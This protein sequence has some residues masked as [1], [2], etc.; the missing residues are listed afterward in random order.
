MASLDLDFEL[1]LPAFT[2]SAAL[3]VGAETLALVGP[4]GAGKTT[5][6]RAVAGLADP[7]RGSI[8]LD[9][10]A[11]FESERDLSLPPEQ[12]S[13]G[14][15]FQDYALFPH[16]SVRRNVAFGARS[17]EAE[18]D[19]LLERFRIAPLREAKPTTLS[20]G[21]RQRVA[22]ARALARRP[23][24]LLL[25]EPLSALDAHTR[26]A[27]KVELQELLAE[28]SLPTIFITHDFRDAAALADRA[29]ALV[30]GRVRQLGS[31]EDLA[32]RPAD[33]AVAALTGS[34]LLSAMARPE[35]DGAIL[36]LPDGQ[37]LRV[38]TPAAGEVGV[39]I[40]PWD[41]RPLAAQPTANGLRGTVAGVTRMGGRV[42]ARV[43]SVAVECAASDPAA[44]YLVEG[45]QA[46]VELPAA[47]I[48][49]V[50][51]PAA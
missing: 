30:D 51:S 46:W 32:Q 7:D 39:A 48:T 25:D 28:L 43:G 36:A 49:L 16:L 22:L 45:E 50:E 34:N 3:E 44:R 47:A 41:V 35:G 10:Q 21:E 14:F 29:A 27:I 8:R 33:A 20:G 5:A 19:E 31:V 11:W 4:S 23:G 42:E 1:T 2:V 13:V 38:P 18:V 12:R 24:V 9:G 37:E 26:A 15:V 6:L 17:G 40:G